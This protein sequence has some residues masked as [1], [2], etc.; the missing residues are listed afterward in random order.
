MAPSSSPQKKSFPRPFSVIAGALLVLLAIG[1]SD[2]NPSVFAD[3]SQ[4]AVGSESDR[5]P[6]EIRAHFINSA[7]D[8]A[9]TNYRQVEEPTSE[10]TGETAF[11]EPPNPD[12]PVLVDLGLYIIEITAINIADNTFRMEG[13]LDLI[14]CDPRLAYAVTPTGR[15]EEIFLEEAALN[16]IQEIWWP[17]IEFVNEAGAS[18]IENTELI[19]LPDGT[20][21]YQHRFNAELENNYD[22]R[23]FPFDRQLLEIEIE[24]FA[25]DTDYH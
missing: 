23:Q 19:I 20:I 11:V 4:V 14:W 15:Q 9:Q 2:G 8:C 13:F 16:K 25:W 18:E 6:G 1:L 24:S 21:N 7:A 22:L 12:G 10:E 17:D 5:L 3:A